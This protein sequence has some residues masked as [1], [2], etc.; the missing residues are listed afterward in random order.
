MNLALRI[1]GETHKNTALLFREM[2]GLYERQGKWEEAEKYYAR[3]LKARDTQWGGPFRQRFR[4]IGPH[5]ASDGTAKAGRA[6]KRLSAP[7][8][9]EKHKGEDSVEVADTLNDLAIVAGKH[10]NP[11]EAEKLYRRSLIIREKT[12]GPK[13]LVVAQSLSNLGLALHDLEQYK[14]AEDAHRRSLA[15]REKVKGPNDRWPPRA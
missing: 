7:T 15:I 9:R 5:V 13:S 14:D 12:D 8:I 11:A 6:E 3:S 4:P 10:G 2:A 1:Y